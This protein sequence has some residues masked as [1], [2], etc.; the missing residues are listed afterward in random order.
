M[1]D[2]RPLARSPLV[3]AA[4]VTVAPGVRRIVAGNAGLMTGPGTNTYLIGTEEV[5]VLDPG[6]DDVR[7][8]DCILAAAGE[9]IRWIVTTHTHQDHSPLAA[10]SPNARVHA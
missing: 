3:A 4:C 5:A 2:P 10:G 9:S 7:H 1:D 6:P 8:F